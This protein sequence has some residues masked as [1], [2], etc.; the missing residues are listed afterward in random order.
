MLN[1]D[2]SLG[3]VRRWLLVIVSAVLLASVTP[4]LFAQGATKK[5]AA[6]KADA[7][8]AKAVKEEVG[9]A[10]VGEA[11]EEA[12]A[13]SKKKPPA[14]NPL[15]NLFK[16]LFGGAK[17]PGAPIIPQ[18]GPADGKRGGRD[19]IDYR[20]PH[21]PDQTKY[22]RLAASQ[23]A[24]GEFEEATKALQYLLELPDESLVQLADGRW[25]SLRHEAIRMIGQLPKEDYQAYRLQHGAAANQMLVEADAS[26]EAGKY[27]LVA[28]RYFHTEAGL[29][30]ASRMARIHFD[31][32]EFGVAARWIR[33]LSNT[34]A[35]VASNPKWQLK[36]ALTFRLAGDDDAANN[37]LKQLTPDGPRIEIGGNVVDPTKWIDSVAALAAST[38]TPELTEWTHF[39]GNPSHTAKS[40]GGEPLLLQRW[41]HPTTY[42]SGL[43][44]RLETLT[45]NFSDRRLAMLSAFHPL[46]INGKIAFRTLRG[47]QVLDAASGSP[48]WET[49]E[50]ISAERI[51]TGR[52]KKTSSQYNRF[53]RGY[54]TS[55][56]E[57]QLG[58]LLFRDGVYGLLSSDG[59]RLFVLEDHAVLVGPTNNYGWGFGG[60]QPKDAFHRDRVSNRITAYDLETGRPAWDVGGMAAGDVLDSPLSGHYFFGPPVA[61]GENLFAIAEHNKEIRLVAMDA[62]TGLRQWSQL[63]AY[64]DVEI[65]KDSNRRYWAAQVGVGNGV[66]VCPTT[67]GLIVGVDRTDHSLLWAQRYSQTVA[68]PTGRSNSNQVPR[69]ELNTRWTPSAPVIVGNRVVCA[70]SEDQS[71][72]CLDL[73][74]GSVLWRKPR[75]NFLSLAGVHDGRVLLVGKETVTALSLDN[76]TT[77]WTRSIPTEQGPPAGQGV[78]VDN[79]FYLPFQNG[80]LWRVDL[81]NGHVMA[82]FERGDGKR[83]LG[84]LLMYQGMLLSQG[85]FGLESFEQKAAIETD[86]QQRKQRN[87][88]DPF[89]LLR[90]SDIFTLEHDDKS[91]LASLSQ[92]KPEE[93]TADLRERY[94]HSLIERLTAVIRTDVAQHDHEM[95]RLKE[96]VDSNNGLSS[97]ANREKLG[98]R[99][100]LAEQLLAKGQHEAAF[101]LYE[102]LAREEDNSLITPTDSPLVHVRARRWVAGRLA[103]LWREM[104]QPTREAIDRRIIAR[105]AELAKLSTADRERFVTLYGFHPS[106]K[107]AERDLIEAYA[108]AGD[109]VQAEARLVR[110][111]AESDSATAAWAVER[112]ARLLRDASAPNDAAVWYRTLETRFADVKLA[113]GNTG[114][115]TGRELT[116]EFAATR[117][118]PGATK[119]S[120]TDWGEFDLKFSRTG[121]SSSERFVRELRISRGAAP[122]FSD[123]R[124]ERYMNVP[125]LGFIDTTDESH[126]WLV[127]LRTARRSSQGGSVVAHSSGHV[128]FVL[129]GDTLHALSPVDR[130]LLWTREVG[131]QVSGASSYRSP[132]ASSHQP[133]QPDS[134]IISRDG[135]RTQ[136][137]RQGMLAVANSEYVCVYGRRRI[138]VL[139]ALTGIIRWTRDDIPKG[140]IVFGNENMLFIIPADQSKAT[141]LAASDGHQL[142][143]PLATLTDLA[144]KAIHISR[145]GLVLAESKSSGG[146][147]GLGGI[148]TIIRLHDP[149]TRKDVWKL[150]YP[151]G[152]YLA[153]LEGGELAALKKDGSLETVDLSTG[154]TTS[155]G[156]V[157]PESLKSIS[158]RNIVVDGDNLYL[159]LA[160]S[161]QATNYFGGQS[162]PSMPVNG[163]L[164]AFSRSSKKQIW[165]HNVAAQGLLVQ[166]LAHSP[167]LTFV[168]RQYSRKGNTGYWSTDLLVLDKRDGRKLLK[169]SIPTNNG[170]QSLSIDGR[171][172]TIELRSHNM[173]L[174]LT[175]ED[176]KQASAK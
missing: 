167:V 106:A 99:R 73:H 37:L 124:I 114:G 131:R 10:E 14:A 96:L 34:N 47:V 61:D 89:A 1:H 72:L 110:I 76:G 142:D 111:A 143:V 174:R 62:V 46:T 86:I 105:A 28:N 176:R 140:T 135:L 139:D 85:P 50:G 63:I 9:K 58:D 42:D 116:A 100:L 49:V 15:G 94:R 39:M 16:K 132:S 156:T 68:K 13:A 172:R 21:D 53:G 102:E 120:M 155:F 40:V 126:H 74:S 6:K 30:A 69:T 134:S 123:H 98:Y 144:N 5:A 136:A 101:T 82:T 163:N 168:K 95:E 104:P 64:T 170:I 112:L 88:R 115:K 150:E 153:V 81:A 2:R 36:A 175:A 90:E 92:I 159:S 83:P 66:L 91:A 93:V 3:Q 20:A 12:K 43:V 109:L 8:Q 146:I 78:V 24:E 32:G 108:I 31:R 84:N 133:M 130:K 35:T 27:A 145:A 56:N 18:R 119:T 128:L 51:L 169:T 38:E 33:R 137:S 52:A 147:F 71:L 103:K 157:A 55:N 23:I 7:P 87:P 29:T 118:K 44:D 77:R 149:T 141:A 4:A 161:R 164:I 17:K 117:K 121:S 48:L 22:L 65:D 127:P 26:G 171:K 54:S 113:G 75:G 162:L 152:T 138:E 107:T 45:Q 160:R 19:K 59:R 41:S 166:H 154:T 67:V 151:R 129:Y 79:E 165:S 97:Q 173:C 57:Q 148:K 70:P 25:G 122:F 125:H 11:K 60:N 158:S 80:S